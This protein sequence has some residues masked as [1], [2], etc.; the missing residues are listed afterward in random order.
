MVILSLSPYLHIKLHYIVNPVCTFL[1]NEQIR[2]PSICSIT[3]SK[4]ITSN[5]LNYFIGARSPSKKLINR[6]TDGSGGIFYCNEIFF[7]DFLIGEINKRDLTYWKRTT[8]K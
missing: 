6:S 1:L 5:Q 7:I 4:L 2:T 3:F 8:I